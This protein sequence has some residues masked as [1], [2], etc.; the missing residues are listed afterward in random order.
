M[1]KMLEKVS[2]ERTGLTMEEVLVTPELAEELFKKRANNNRNLDSKYINKYALDMKKNRWVPGP[3]SILSFSSDGIL[4]NGH[5]RLKAIIKAGV[6]IPM[7]LEENVP[8][9]SMLV[10]DTGNKRNSGEIF[11]IHGVKEDASIKARASRVLINLANEKLTDSINNRARSS[12]ITERD[13]LNYFKKNEEIISKGASVAKKCRKNNKFIP[14]GTL[15]AYYVIFSIANKERVDEFFDK[16]TTGA[17][18]EEDNPILIIINRFQKEASSKNKM[19]KLAKISLFITSWN[20]FIQEKTGNF[21][22]SRS[23][24]KVEDSDG[25]EVQ[26]KVL[27]TLS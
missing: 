16:F 10:M 27:K 14:T 5:H 11:Q 23:F 2:F 6:S 25:N 15:A 7:I 20:R 22:V 24:V 18:L 19:T 26:N 3:G 17:N 8:K 13:I 12:E 1:N 4:L 9:E 21:R